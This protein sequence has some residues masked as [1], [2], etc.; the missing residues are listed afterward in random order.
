MPHIFISHSSKDKVWAEELEGRLEEQ[1]NSSHFLDFHPIKGIVV[2][3]K[4]EPKL[5]AQLR[6]CDA[7]VFLL[8]ESKL[9]GN[10]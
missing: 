1:K 10:G 5:Y 6:R 3:R 7:V 9:F 2:S 4:W 8:S